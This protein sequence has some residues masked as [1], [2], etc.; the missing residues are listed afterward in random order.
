MLVT[1][2]W[3]KYKV[4]W[5][6]ESF[7]G[8]NLWKKMEAIFGFKAKKNIQKPEENELRLKQSYDSLYS[9]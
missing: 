2:I 3:T 5:T 9:V 7:D 6:A 1:D 8:G 4:F